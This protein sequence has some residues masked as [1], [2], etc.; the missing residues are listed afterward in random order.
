MHPLERSQA[1]FAID[2]PA[3]PLSENSDCQ[4]VTRGVTRR[5]T[6]PEISSYNSLIYLVSPSGFEPETY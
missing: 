6:P 1:I 4:A 2:G 3:Q 5:L